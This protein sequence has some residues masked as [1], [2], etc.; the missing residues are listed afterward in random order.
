MVEKIYRGAMGDQE[1]KTRLERAGILRDLEQGNINEVLQKLPDTVSMEDVK[2]FLASQHSAFAGNIEQMERV[3]SDQAEPPTPS[4]ADF[5]AFDDS[6]K[7]DAADRGFTKKILRGM[8]VKKDQTSSEGPMTEQELYD[9]ADDVLGEAEELN[10]QIM[11]SIMMAQIESQN[12]KKIQEL[13]EEL[14]KLIAMAKSGEIDVSFLIL[15]LTKVKVAQEGKVV[16]GISQDIARANAETNRI[17]NELY[18][19][20]SQAGFNEIQLG[21]EKIREQTFSLQQGLNSLNKA[22]EG[23]AGSISFCDGMIKYIRSIQHEMLG[24]WGRG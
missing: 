3:R 8:T 18:G 19:S 12:E 2:A 1:L 15:A 5:P 6:A 11:D 4:P 10:R 16:A 14:Q 24:K 22:M 20:G 23:I 17:S 21:S 13:K 7:M 9:S